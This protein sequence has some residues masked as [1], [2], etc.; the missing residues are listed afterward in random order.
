MTLLALAAQAHASGVTNSGNDLRDG[1][2]P[3]QPSLT[4]Q[5]VSGGSFGQLWSAPVEGQVYA[6]PLLAAGALLV[7]TQKNN[8]YS[9]DPATGSRNWSRNLGTPWNPA[10]VG[11]ADLTPWI[12]VT[13]TPVIDTESNTAYLTHK[14]Y[15]SG[16]SGAARWYMDAIDLTS[17]AERSGFPVELSGTAQNAPGQK[18]SPTTQLQRPG[19][20]LMNGVVYAAFGSHCDVEPWQGWVFGVST[21]G[22]IK[23]RWVTVASGSGAGIWQSGSGL[24][25]DGSG[26]ILLSTG[27]GGAPPSPTPGSAPPSNLGESVVR[28]RVQSDGS[29]KATDFFA[30]FDAATLDTWDADFASGGVT[31]LP[32]E[33]FGTSAIPHLAVAVGKSGYVYLLNR[34]NLGGIA[35][36]PSGSDKVV[37]RIGPYGGVW[38]RPGVWPGEGGWVYIPTAS[39]GTTGSA[40]AGN[41]RVYQ[42][43]ESGSGAPTLSLQATSS[44]VFGFSSSAP[45]ITSDGTKAGSALV[46]MVWAP[47]GGGGG[48]Q[49]RA[50]DPVPVGGHPVLRWSA[51]VG[52]S[53]KFAMPGVGAGRIYVGTRDEH[54]L[55]FGSPVTPVLSGPAT[56]FPTTTI[57]STSQKTVTLTANAHVT[58]SSLVSSTSQFKLGAPSKVLPATMEP[59]DTIEVPVT[60]APTGAGPIGGTLTAETSTGKTYGFG[61]SGVGQAAAAQLEATPPL[62]T[63]GGTS[64]GEQLSGS[65]AFRNVGGKSLTIENVRVPGAPFGASGVPA[66]HSSIA[67]GASVTVTVT[68]EPKTVGMFSGEIGLETTGGNKAVGLT[69]S[70]GLP[71]TLTVSSEANDY[72]AVNVGASATRT[73]TV[74][75]TGGTSVTIMKSKPPA[76]GA[77]AAATSLAEGTT[78]EPGGSVAEAVTFTPVATGPAGG[79]WLITGNDTTGPHAV[80]FSGVGAVPTETVT[81]IVQQPPGQGPPLEHGVLGGN[82][83]SPAVPDARLAGT[84]LTV[85]RSGIVTV[86]VRCPVAVRSCAG[87]ITLRTLTLAAAGREGLTRKLATLV[88]AAGPFTVGGGRQTTVRLALTARGRSLLAGR[89]LL[90]AR[91]IIVAHD[92]AGTTHVTRTLVTIR[93]PKAPAAAVRR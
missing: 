91:A 9:L 55:G 67:P 70:A 47:N 24:T 15:A 20:L 38:S 30:P 62:V 32:D 10:D 6:Q 37:Q 23:A 60:F 76:G 68:F 46:W 81:Q 34:D 17:G 27:N 50:Y 26:T 84:S 2:Y 74:T 93:M 3:D 54:V 87:R 22:Q 59:G 21:G 73:F 79:E 48:A 72:G 49:L 25:S 56:S 75:N 89:R 33:Y 45:V 52:T 64:V 13:A 35:Q 71:G 77:F 40:T 86:P 85:S 41:L 18:F 57:G 19:L 43:G 42:Y 4:P 78:I 31:G 83:G 63:F 36:G 29:L 7:A 53:S 92:P 90:Q 28:L 5:L 80:H 12:G 66:V 88:L 11:C 39:G 69:G 16:S 61:L 8:V 65:V 1:W 44:D 58:V 51:A 82:E 14:T